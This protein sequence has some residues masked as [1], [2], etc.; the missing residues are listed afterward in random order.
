MMSDATFE[1]C[2]RGHEPH[3]GEKRITLYPGAADFA[4][5][6]SYSIAQEA[7]KAGIQAMGA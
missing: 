2:F 6:L 5:Q 1:H 7:T 4:Q 3:V